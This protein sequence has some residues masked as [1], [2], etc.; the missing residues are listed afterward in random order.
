MSISEFPTPA[1]IAVIRVPIS[2]DDNILSTLARSTFK[3]FPL[4]GR[5][6]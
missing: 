4:N 5:I 3:I 1:P 6:A 2:A